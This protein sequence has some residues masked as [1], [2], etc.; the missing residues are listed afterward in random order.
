MTPKD[1][2]TSFFVGQPLKVLVVDGLLADAKRTVQALEDHGYKVRADVVATAEEFMQKLGEQTYDVVLSELALPGWTGL[3]VLDLLKDLQQCLPFIL[4]T[5]AQVDD[6]AGRLID[7]G[8]DDYVLKDKLSR[9]PLAVRRV[10]REQRLFSELKAATEERERLIRSLQ[11][12]LAEVKRLNGLLPICVSCKRV[13][14]AQGFWNRIEVFIERYSDAR[15]SPSLC[16]SCSAK[17]V[18]EHFN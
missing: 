2:E 10:M 5:N 9:L 15:V 8:A 16:P 14:S 18:P 4:V 12:T 11:E 1:F 6:T 3:D 7:Q 17:T 13:L